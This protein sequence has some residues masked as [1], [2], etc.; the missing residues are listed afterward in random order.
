MQLTALL[1]A[2]KNIEYETYTID[3]YTIE[4]IVKNNFDIIIELIKHGADWT[5]TVD[6]ENVLD[7][8]NDEYR[9][10]LIDMFPNKFDEYI[11]SK[12]GE[13]YNL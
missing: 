5:I 12:D 6:D 1:Y 13:I 4:N 11:I 8:L 2:G 9:N 7:C 3:D 10:I